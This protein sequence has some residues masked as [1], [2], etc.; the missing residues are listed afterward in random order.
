VES[1]RE[2]DG[3]GVLPSNAM[4]SAG[5]EIDLVEDKL[6]LSFWRASKRALLS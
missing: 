2:G 5:G 6:R 3:E 4:S 1:G